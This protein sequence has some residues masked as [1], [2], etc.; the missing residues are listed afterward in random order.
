[1]FFTYFL[2]VKKPK[3]SIFLIVKLYFYIFSIIRKNIAKSYKTFCKAIM[4]LFWHILEE[5]E[6]GKN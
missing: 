3:K 1:L 6:D 2:Y 5:W 4:K